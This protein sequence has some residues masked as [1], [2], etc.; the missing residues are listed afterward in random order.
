MVKWLAIFLLGLGFAVGNVYKFSFF[1]PE[2]RLTP[3]D[4]IVIVLTLFTL[5]KSFKDPQLWHPVEAFFTIGVVSLLFAWQ[6]FGTSAAMIGGMY[7]GRWVMYTLFFVSLVRIFK[8]HELVNLVYVLGL[9]TVVVSLLQYI[10]YPDIRAL[11]LLEW[12]P[13]YFRVVGSWL[14][15]GFTGVLLV[16]ILLWLTANPFKLRWQQLAAW[17]SAYLAFALT[18]SRSSYLAFLGGMAWL[19]WKQKGWKFLVQMTLLLGITILLLP[20]A[21]DG[22]GVKLERA[23]SIWS[24]LDSWKYAWTIFTDHPVLGVGFNTYRY[25]QKDYG[26]ISPEK[27]QTTHAGAGADSSLLFV[28]ATT[29]ILGLIAYLWYLKRIFGMGTTN[30]A[31]GATLVALVVHSWFLNSLFYPPIILWLALLIAQRYNASRA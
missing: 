28:A 12:D 21:P 30:L 15:P 9:V 5:L 4:C 16:F 23:Y 17:I 3:L 29:G 6:S 26:F 18:Y 19:A 10:I 24:R 11:Q 22:E 1:S 2:V 14:D 7:L 25:A 31:L 8:V 27:W 13:H 20:R